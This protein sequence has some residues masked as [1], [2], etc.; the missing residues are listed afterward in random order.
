MQVFGNMI[1]IPM[2]KKT[3]RE[4]GGQRAVLCCIHFLF[5]QFTL[6][7]TWKPLIWRCLLLLKWGCMCANVGYY[8][9]KN[10]EVHMLKFK[11]LKCGEQFLLQ[12]LA[13]KITYQHVHKN[14]KTFQF[15][16]VVSS[17]RMPTLWKSKSL[18]KHCWL[19]LYVHPEICPRNEL[20]L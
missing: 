16:R 6:M 10:T 13:E 3:E 12:E 2:H 4:S 14:D 9:K 7:M 18:G 17:A 8:L 11:S 19:P 20:P 15:L 5:F 1:F